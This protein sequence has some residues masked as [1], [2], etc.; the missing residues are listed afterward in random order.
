MVGAGKGGGVFDWE[1]WSGAQFEFDELVNQSTVVEFELLLRVH[2]LFG[3]QDSGGSKMCRFTTYIL[4]T[5]MGISN[6]LRL[7]GQSSTTGHAPHWSKRA[8]AC[9]M[10]MD[11][12]FPGRGW[13]L[14]T[15]MRIECMCS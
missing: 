11:A 12:G 9:C 10:N 7:L 6:T 3:N 8:Q 13:K 5:G 15:C 2:C 4:L 1:F 14:E